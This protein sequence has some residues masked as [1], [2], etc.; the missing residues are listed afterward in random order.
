LGQDIVPAAE[1][2]ASPT[3]REAVDAAGEFIVASRSVATLKAYASDWKHFLE[4]CSREPLITLPASPG[5]V[6]A[7]LAVL[8]TGEPPARVSTIRRRC[9]AIAHFH[10]QA[11]Y[12]NP[13]EHAGVRAVLN[14]IARTLGARPDKKAPATAEVLAQ[15]LRKI[16]NDLAGLRDRA[17]ILIGFAGALRRSEMVALDIADIG[18]HPKGVLVTV[19]RS[20]TDQH[21]VGKTKAV[22]FGRKLRPVAALDAWLGALA[23]TGV[24]EGPLFRGVHGS[25][26]LP[27]RLCAH[28][29]AAIIKKR[30]A[31]IGLDA[32]AFSGHSLRGGYITTA[33]E[34]NA[35]LQ[36]IADQAGHSKLDTT[37]S[38]VQIADSFRDHS[39]QK[40][41]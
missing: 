34:N 12:L 33:A 17:L 11:S 5:T 40:F 24:I 20:K 32:A 26:V 15:A 22:P 28:Q 16:P 7:Y 13:C 10:R 21:G 29:V 19:R 36:K 31:A 14:G 25:K 6:A 8:A 23:A 27:R 39:G 30:V 4:W 3:L 9:A 1:S 18:R 38:Y 35:A 41:L 37:R 2:S